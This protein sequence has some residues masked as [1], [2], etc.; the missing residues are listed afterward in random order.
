MIDQGNSSRTAKVTSTKTTNGTAGSSP[1]NVP[2]FRVTGSVFVKRIY[3]VVLVVLGANHTAA[4]LRTNDQT[5]QIQLTAVGGTVLSAAPVGSL[6]VKDGLAA[7]AITLKSSAAG[8]VLEPAT[9]DQEPFSP[10]TV[11]QKTG[12]VNTDIEYHYAT[13]D[14]P[15]SGQIQFFCEY[16]PLT[17]GA[18]VTPL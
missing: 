1:F 18:T 9:V 12:G 8:A 16:V 14:A 5:A 3:G 7:A 10:F 4:A 2:I 15:T 13:T 6:I 11:T 17:D